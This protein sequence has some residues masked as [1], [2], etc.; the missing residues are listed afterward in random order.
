MPLLRA[1]LIG[2][3]TCLRCGRVSGSKFAGCGRPMLPTHLA[4]SL[5]Y[6]Q[7]ENRKNDSNLHR[8]RSRSAVKPASVRK[9]YERLGLQ[10]TS[11]L[12]EAREAYFKLAKVYH[13][14]TIQKQGETEHAQF[15]EIALAYEL[16]VEDI[17]ERDANEA[18][19]PGFNP[20]D[21][22]D[23]KHTAPQHRQYL[24]NWDVGR[25]T[26]FQRQKRRQQKRFERAVDA[27]VDMEKMRSIKDGAQGDEEAALVA[28]QQDS[29]REYVRK[30]QAT[31]GYTRLVEDMITEAMAKGDFD[32]LKGKGK[33]IKYKS[34]S[35]FVDRTTQKMQGLM[36]H[37]GLLPEWIE[38]DKDIRESIDRVR[39][40]CEYSWHCY[41]NM[42]TEIDEMMWRDAEK[43][44]RDSIN[45]LNKRIDHFNLIVPI[46]RAQKM[47]YNIEYE[48]DKIRKITPVPPESKPHWD[49][50]RLREAK[51]RASTGPGLLERIMNVLTSDGFGGKRT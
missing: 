39:K 46:L 26:V 17:E 37:A 51:Q 8:K 20:D 50:A 1:R 23:I 34:A 15:Q 14:D 33:P 28:Q 16:I 3:Q 38:Q 5:Y 13:P 7:F 2:M 43:R 25:G 27:V 4:R 40:K 24:E 19:D 30:R 21:Y 12:E 35:P 47:H 9:A 36:H 42:E 22:P 6:Q 41:G 31:K 10:E 45:H 32:N 11:S 44:M 48:L 49:A 18:E 29:A